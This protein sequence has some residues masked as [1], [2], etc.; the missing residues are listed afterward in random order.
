M[1]IVLDD[2][3]RSMVDKSRRWFSPVALRALQPRAI[4]GGRERVRVTGDNKTIKTVVKKT[5]STS[6]AVESRNKRARKTPRWMWRVIIPKKRTRRRRRRPTPNLEES[7][8]LLLRSST[9]RAADAAF[10]NPRREERGT[11]RG[12]NGNGRMTGKEGREHQIISSNRRRAARVEFSGGGV[13]A[14]LPLPS[15]SPRV[16]PPIGASIGNPRNPGLRS[17]ERSLLCIL[18]GRGAAISPRRRRPRRR[19]SRHRTPIN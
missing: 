1:E 8:H 7:W 18:S 17:S 3:R 11:K 16:A 13:C 12:T 15:D 5:P 14:A 6:A 10:F 9:T 2:R 4:C 19:R